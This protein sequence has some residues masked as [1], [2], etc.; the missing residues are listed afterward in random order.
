MTTLRELRQSRFLEQRELAQL[1]GVS[2]ASI[3]N[4]E[5]GKKRPRLSH[6]RKLA[7]LL[8]VPPKDIEFGK[9]EE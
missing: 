6:I 2:E 1:M 9:P 4:W 3:S 8:G 7:E 5:T